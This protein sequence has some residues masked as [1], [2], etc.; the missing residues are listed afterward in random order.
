MSLCSN[1]SVG[2]VE[3]MQMEKHQDGVTQDVTATKAPE[4]CKAYVFLQGM[5]WVVCSDELFQ[6]SK[7]KVVDTMH[8]AALFIWKYVCVCWVVRAF[9]R[10]CS[11]CLLLS[12]TQSCL[13]CYRLQ[14]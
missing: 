6:A 10:A 4:I 14:C 5:P 9:P 3:R 8:S 7:L 13:S 11:C 2:C 12:N 1:F